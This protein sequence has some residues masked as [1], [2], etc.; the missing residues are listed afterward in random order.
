MRTEI[1]FFYVLMIKPNNYFL[2]IFYVNNS[3]L[4]KTATGESIHYMDLKFNFK[5]TL[6]FQFFVLK[7]VDLLFFL[8]NY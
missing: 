3:F 6:Y 7:I 1:N 8:L 4:L 2:F 5:A